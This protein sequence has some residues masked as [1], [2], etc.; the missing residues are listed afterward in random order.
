[1]KKLVLASQSP[2]RKEILKQVGLTFEIQP[3]AIH[4]H[5]SSHSTVQDSIEELALR[6]AK[7]VA[8]KVQGDAIVLG[9]D[10]IV[11]LDGKILGK[12]RSREDA[13]SMLRA[14][15][16]KTHSVLTGIGLIDT[17]T[18]RHL[19]GHQRTHVTMKPYG[20]KEILGYIDSGECWDKAGAYGIQGLGALLVQEIRGDYFN[21]VGLPV[22]LLDEMLKELDYFIL[23]GSGGQ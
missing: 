16:G 5:I 2:R 22:G 6:K 19:K 18:G 21:V 13:T 3:S 15:S 23:V 7:D 12:P 9:A 11:L 8:D 17:G 4:E 14:L 10:T 1:M 20:M